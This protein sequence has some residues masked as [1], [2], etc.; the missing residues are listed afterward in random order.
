MPS[1]LLLDAQEH[2]RAAIELHVLGGRADDRALGAACGG[3]AEGESLKSGD[4]LACGAKRAA[5]RDAA[6]AIDRSADCACGRSGYPA[7]GIAHGADG[8]SR[9]AQYA[10][11]CTGRASAA[12]WGESCVGVFTCEAAGGNAGGR[13]KGLDYCTQGYFLTAMENGAVEGDPEA[14]FRLALAPSL[15]FGDVTNQF[16]SFVQHHFAIGL[17]VFGEFGCDF[18]AGFGF[19]GIQWFREFSLKS[20]SAIEASGGIAGRGIDR[21]S[22]IC[23]GVSTGSSVSVLALLCVVFSG[24]I[25]LT[26][27]VHTG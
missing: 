25:A 11:T 27:S 21:A 18:I 24:S 3:G 22:G 7:R 12:G 20:G 9:A 6:N 13:R 10:A 1:D 8:A 2:L 23:A 4:A 17:N 19:F 26:G 15:S 14:G 5:S 16:R